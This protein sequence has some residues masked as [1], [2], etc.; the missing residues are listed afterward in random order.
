MANT[1]MTAKNTFGDGLVL[2]ISPENTGANNLSSALNATLI[3]ANGN[4]MTLQNDMGNARVETAYLPDGYIPIGTCEFGDIIYIVSYNPLVNKAQIGCF[5]SPER[6]IS[7]EEISE[8]NQSLSSTDFQILDTNGNPT[9][10]L[11]TMQIKKTLFDGKKLR[12]GD[13]YIIYTT[14]AGDGDFIN[15]FFKHT[16]QYGAPSINS[17]FPK[18]VK[19]RVASMDSEGKLTYLDSQTNWYEGR[20]GKSEDY[21]IAFLQ[22]SG[23][24]PDIDSYRSLTSSAYSIFQNK[25]AGN[26]VLVAELEKINSF[27]CAYSVIKTGEKDEDGKILDKFDVYLHVSW[28]TPH[29]DINPFGIRITGDAYKLEFDNGIF[30]K[31]LSRLYIPEGKKEENEDNKYT[32]SGINYNDYKTSN[33]QNSLQ[34]E[35][36]WSKSATNYI[37]VNTHYGKSKLTIEN[38]NIYIDDPIQGYIIVPDF[39]WQNIT[40][41]NNPT[42]NSST[43][44]KQD[45]LNMVA[46]KFEAMSRISL[47]QTLDGNYWLQEETNLAQYYPNLTKLSKINGEISASTVNLNGEDV[48]IKP[49]VFSADVVNN[50]FKKDYTIHLASVDYIDEKLPVWNIMVYPCMPYGYLEHLGVP[51]TIDFSKVGTNSIDLT[52]WKYYNDGLLSTLTYGFDMNLANNYKVKQVAFEFYDDKGLV[53]VYKSNEKTSYSGMFTERFGLNGENLNYKLSNTDLNGELIYHAGSLSSEGDVQ[54][55]SNGI[56]IPI[57]KKQVR[58]SLPQVDPS[59]KEPIPEDEFDP[60]TGEGEIQPPTDKEEVEGETEGETGNG[61]DIPTEDVT[62]YLNDSGVLYT[63]KLYGVK[64]IV[65]YGVVNELGEMINTEIKE[66]YRW[67]WTNNMFNDK[68]FQ[69]NDFNFDNITLGLECNYVLQSRPDFKIQ[70]AAYYKDG[71]DITSDNLPKTLGADVQYVDQKFT[72][73]FIPGL[74][75]NDTFIPLD[76]FPIKY[77]VGLGKKDIIQKYNNIIS[78]SGNSVSEDLLKPDYYLE[79]MIGISAQLKKILNI[80]KDV[81]I[82]EEIWDNPNSYKS[83][84]SSFI[85]SFDS[86]DIPDDS[87]SY[88]IPE[89]E[90]QATVNYYIS[91]EFNKI[92]E[93]MSYDKNIS[94]TLNLEGISFDKVKYEQIDEHSGK[95]PKIQSVFENSKI[96]NLFSEWN[97]DNILSYYYFNESLGLTLPTRTEHGRCR[98]FAYKNPESYIFGSDMYNIKAGTYLNFNNSELLTAIEQTGVK[99]PIILINWSRYDTDDDTEQEALFINNLMINKDNKHYNHSNL[100]RIHTENING[101]GSG[102]FMQLALYKP[103]E[104]I[105]LLND[106]FNFHLIDTPWTTDNMFSEQQPYYLK[107]HKMYYTSGNEPGYESREGVY[108]I[109]PNDIT[110]YYQTLAHLLVNVYQNLYYQ[111]SESIDYKIQIFKDLAYTQDF[112]ETWSQHFVIKL[113]EYNSEINYSNHILLQ[114]SPFGIDAKKQSLL[115]YMNR[116]ISNNLE[117]KPIIVNLQKTQQI[118]DFKFELPKSELLKNIYSNNTQNPQ[119]IWHKYSDDVDIPVYKNFQNKLLFNENGQLSELQGDFKYT[120]DNIEYTVKNLGKLIT[121]DKDQ[122]IGIYQYPNSNQYSIASG[123]TSKQNDFRSYDR[124][125]KDATI[126]GFWNVI[127]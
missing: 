26:L 60:S 92:Q 97:Q 85:I 99:G 124:A 75:E 53:A 34:N 55:D 40:I 32:Y 30:E 42:F 18:L 3:T 74:S 101:D 103:G 93:E 86:S 57:Q 112:I 89:L 68:Y 8:L 56:S 121:Y 12:P 100:P 125:S 2:D 118:I 1:I 49:V 67:Y 19:L 70:Q 9:G 72:L 46:S 109:N 15:D 63:N 27:N 48:L 64:I 73:S 71:L 23:D 104:Y 41:D 10:E 62:T 4:E 6:N 38:N 43:N 79:G 47:A 22:K 61:S 90:E 110:S 69:Q 35:I 52:H 45:L 21:F 96:K 81:S 83:Y 25:N 123:D 80:Q 51:L 91:G 105:Y 115:E 44:K 31:S 116:I 82:N 50:Y 106:V 7:S 88:I 122:I 5:P 54:L 13:K 120:V 127:K 76:N 29:N 65:E 59:G 39:Y 98:Y 77:K 24:V 87:E 84:K 20:D 126:T 107:D 66:F 94:L 102:A 36:S 17:E 28:D 16:S 111:D 117:L 11:K 78:E 58:E 95:Y 14:D 113:E 119:A 33:Y 37:E 114:T 108:K